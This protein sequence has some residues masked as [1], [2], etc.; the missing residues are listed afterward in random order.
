MCGHHGAGAR[1][2]ARLERRNSV[3]S[4]ASRG[5]LTI[6]RP[7]W[8][9]T[10]VS[11][12][13]ESASASRSCR[14]PGVRDARSRVSRRRI[15]AV[16]PRVDH[17]LRGLFTSTTGAKLTH[18]DRARLDRGDLSRFVRQRLV[19]RAPNAMLRGNVV[20]PSR[21]KPAP[22]SKSAEFSSGYG[23]IACRRLRI[24][25]AA[26]GCPSVTC[27]SWRP[28]DVWRGLGAAEHVEAADLHSCTA[29]ASPRIR[30]SRCRDTRRRTTRRGAARPF[31]RASSSSAWPRPSARPRDRVSGR[32]ADG[33]Q[34][35][36]GGRN[37]RSLPRGWRRERR[38]RPVREVAWGGWYPGATGKMKR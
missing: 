12:W 20:A 27:R 35:P 25:A 2:D 33:F 30:S 4:S 1:G 15:L 8:E 7:R 17:R 24:D 13:P 6:G 31:R 19:T 21:R 34:L 36:A 28:A 5:S 16:G 38:P 32:P 37:S 26:S 14:R 9:S 3:A 23:A 18:A 11:P 10:S 29:F 22:V